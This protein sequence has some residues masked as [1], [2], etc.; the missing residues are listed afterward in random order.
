MTSP[1]SRGSGGKSGKGGRVRAV[2]WERDAETLDLVKA[3]AVE[4]GWEVATAKSHAS[5]TEELEETGADLLFIEFPNLYFAAEEALISFASKHPRTAVVAM[6]ES[7]RCNRIAHLLDEGLADCLIKPIDEETL[8]A[9]SDRALA[10]LKRQIRELK[11][12]Q[13]WHRRVLGVLGIDVPVNGQERTKVRPRLWII[14]ATFLIALIG[15]SFGFLEYSTSPRFCNSCHIMKP[16]VEAWKESTHS[17]VGCVDCHYPPNEYWKTKFQAISQVAAWVTGTYSTK[18]Y[19]EIDDANCLECH[20]T[21]LLEGK[22]VFKRGIK[23]DHVPHLEKLRRG[24]KLK[25]T[26][27][28]AQIV[29]G[30]HVAVNERV[31]FICHFMGKVKGIEPQSQEFCTHCHFPPEDDIELAGLTYNHKDFVESGVECQ[32]CHLEAVEGEGEVHQHMCYTCHGEPERLARIDED[33]FLHKT[34][35][36]EHKVECDQCHSEIQHSVKTHTGPLEY[37]CQI[38][39]SST[40]EGIK[41]MYMGTGGLEVEDQPNPMYLAQVDCIGCHVQSSPPLDDV[42]DLGEKTLRAV[43]RGCTNCHGTDYEGLLEMWLEDVEAD[44][45]ETS[46]LIDAAEAAIAAH[47]SEQKSEKASAFLSRAQYNYHYVRTFHGVHNPDY[48]AALLEKA[49]SDVQ[50][51]LEMLGAS[52]PDQGHPD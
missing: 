46:K 31:C 16:F 20:T 33:E 15:A 18:P 51:V 3:F 14:L 1:R 24:K 32:R 19:A 21:R 7:A 8:L 40:H 35:V 50:K 45:E 12:K 26:T 52:A 13:A 29:Q 49:R 6:V 11:V 34:H 44:L 43:E 10:N 37:D 22:V 38:C 5:L 28:H 23:F 4:Q 25:C 2:V 41:K 27:C 42:V 36:T 17:D 48:S 9:S 39:H 30:E 47:E